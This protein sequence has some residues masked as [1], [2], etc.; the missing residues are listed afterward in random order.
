VAALEQ[1]VE[2]SATPVRALLLTH[3]FG[4]AQQVAPVREFCDAR[5]IVLIEDC[6]HAMFTSRRAPQLGVAG[7][8]V[9]ASPY[10]MFPCD[11]GGLLLAAPDAHL[12]PTRAA[13]LRREARVLAHM[14]QR[15]RA[16]RDA[17][18][19]VAV[20]DLEA[21]IAHLASRPIEPGR[22]TRARFAGTS[23]MYD[24]A[25]EGQACPRVATLIAG[26]CNIEHIARRRRAN[27]RRWSD[28]MQGLPHCRPLFRDLPDDCVPYMF[29]LVIDRPQTHFYLLKK[30]GV[31]IWR[32]DDMAQSSCAVSQHYREHLLHLP[33][34]QALSD[35]GLSW[36]TR[37]VATA[38]Q[39]ERRDGQVRNSMD[40]STDGS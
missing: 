23:Q 9:I 24:A 4:F 18:R 40:G 11:E 27:Y 1:L 13:N 15:H 12:P 32:W 34:H 36:M 22:Q 19:H 25:E 30:L 6:A 28:A 39:L 35:Q 2:R 14:L 26:L 33:C 16:H 3:Y 29:P 10:K 5:G 31:P 37:A 20:D 17:R 38:M 7:R 8:Y 21:E